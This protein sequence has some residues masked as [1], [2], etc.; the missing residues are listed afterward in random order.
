MSAYVL[1]C[2]GEDNNGLSLQTVSQPQL[3]DFLYG[4]AIVVV[5][6]HRVPDLGVTS[7]WQG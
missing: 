5:S 4:V 3:N 1:P 7:G 6:L 2:L